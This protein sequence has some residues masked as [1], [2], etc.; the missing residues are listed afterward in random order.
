MEVFKYLKV[1]VLYSEILKVLGKMAIS[2]YV[3]YKNPVVYVAEEMRGWVVVGRG[4]SKRAAEF[5]ITW[6]GG[7][8]FCVL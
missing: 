7:S 2:P 6:H 3:V 4:S 1:V 5:G 8:C